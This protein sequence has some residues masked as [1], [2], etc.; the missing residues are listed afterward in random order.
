MGRM[1]VPDA[2]PTNAGIR[3]RMIPGMYPSPVAWLWLL[4]LAASC[5]STT[6]DC[7]YVEFFELTWEEQRK[8]IAEY[9][10]DKQIDICLASRKCIYPDV[11]H[12]AGAIASNG[13][14]I[15]PR[16]VDRLEKSSVDAEK[17]D[18]LGVFYHLE[19]S[20]YYPVADDARLMGLLE[21]QIQSIHSEA[22][23]GMAMDSLQR[24]RRLGDRP[25][26]RH[27]KPE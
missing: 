18:L 9:P 14:S 21:R 1:K 25:N 8:L 20:R 26:V 16:L 5:S 23:R 22:Y 27:K 7:A 11:Q 17:A 6:Y 10:L 4:F 24:I 2:V 15:V 19:V 3:S 13:A 12:L